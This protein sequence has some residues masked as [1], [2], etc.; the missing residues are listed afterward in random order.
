MQKYQENKSNVGIWVVASAG[1][2]VAVV[3]W[4]WLPE[5]LTGSY[6]SYTEISDK[7]AFGDT[8]GT[9]N[10]LFTALAFVG[11]ITTILLQKK[12]LQLQRHELSLQRQEMKGQKD[13]LK[14]QNATFKQQRF[15]STFFELLRVHNDIVSSLFTVHSKS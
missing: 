11:L 8:F 3:L 5:Y 1:A 14:F 4:W 6:T 12:E 9:V 7:G 15:E 2:L 10:A 13:Q